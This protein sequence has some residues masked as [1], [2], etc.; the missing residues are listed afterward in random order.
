MDWKVL[1][2]T[3]GV[4][5]LAELGDKTQLAVITLT[6]NQRKPLPIFLGASLA[7][8]FVTL[9][10]VLGGE[11]L[12]RLVPADLLRRLAAVAFVVMGL[13]MWFEVL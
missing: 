7:L 4:L 13:L 12:V 10:G 3:F 6:C 5:F 11:A 9:L 2:S 8:A 1:L